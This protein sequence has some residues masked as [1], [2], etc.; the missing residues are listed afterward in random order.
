MISAPATGTTVPTTA[1]RGATTVTSPLAKPWYSPAIPSAPTMPAPAPHTQ[2]A[3][4]GTGEPMISTPTN[5]RIR[6]TT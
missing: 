4:D 1:L 3:A 5:T 6:L 2:V